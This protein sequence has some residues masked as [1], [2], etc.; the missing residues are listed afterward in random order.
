MV[1]VN[2]VYEFLNT[3]APSQMAMES[4]NVGL[5]VGSGDAGA[6]KILVSLDIT[7]AVISEALDIGANLIVAHH[8]LFFSLTSITDKD[9]VGK[10]IIRLLSEGISAIC[11]HTN[12]DAAKD[13]V[14]DA[15]AVIAGIAD[16][17]RSAEPLSNRCSLSG[18]EVISLG[19]VGH[20]KEPCSMP[21]YLAELKKKLDANGL[22][23]YDA[24][25]DVYRVAIA[26]GSGGSQ[27]DYAIESNCDTFVSAD[28]KYNIFLDAKELGINII[29][30]G[31]FSTENPVIDV[32]VNKLGDAFPKIDVLASQA[33]S[34]VIGFC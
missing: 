23:Y 6:S 4:D 10:K 24:G 31:H 12:L 29:D 22:R 28:L 3:V 5:L 25:C 21:D 34:Q 15:L 30:G 2:D 8:P 19:R 26:S 16:D 32:L 14:N 27:W 17:N 1:T 18:G 13:G 11:M 20:L 9:I 33:H 7:E